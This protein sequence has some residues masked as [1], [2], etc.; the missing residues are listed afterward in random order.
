MPCPKG[1]PRTFATGSAAFDTA[2]GHRVGETAVFVVA[3]GEAQS[4]VAVDPCRGVV[5]EGSWPSTSFGTATVGS[6]FVQ[7]ADTKTVTFDARTNRPRVLAAFPF[8]TDLRCP[9]EIIA[10]K[11]RAVALCP[12]DGK[13]AVLDL[14]KNT[15][16]PAPELP[17]G[18]VYGGGAFD[19][20]IYFSVNSGGGA[21]TLDTQTMVARHVDRTSG[22]KTAVPRVVALGP[23]FLVGEGS[24]AALYDA[25]TERWFP[26]ALADGLRPASVYGNQVLFSADGELPRY[27]LGLHA[28]DFERRTVRRYPPFFGGDQVLIGEATLRLDSSALPS[29]LFRPTDG[30]FVATTVPTPKAEYAATVWTRRGVVAFGEWGPMI[31]G[32]VRKDRTCPDSNGAHCDPIGHVIRPD[33][34]PAYARGVVLPIAIGDGTR[35]VSPLP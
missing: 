18:S 10:A 7:V 12:L 30:T 21:F 5:F 29:L 23:Y 25:A 1:A 15:W 28:Y 9:L 33:R 4:L 19:G 3:R 17:A 20:R 26:L 31:P 34:R 27:T 24:D 35:D 22:P 6:T 16:T 14:A 13:A 8:A 32:I 11:T 2:S